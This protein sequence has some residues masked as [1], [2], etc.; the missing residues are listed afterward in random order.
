MT[1]FF[2]NMNM[3]YKSLFTYKANYI[4]IDIEK[5]LLLFIKQKFLGVQYD[6]KKQLQ[7]NTEHTLE[8][9]DMHIY[10]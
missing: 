7:S 9:T 5:F 1:D 8:L 6:I 10:Q 3:K 2:K 4:S